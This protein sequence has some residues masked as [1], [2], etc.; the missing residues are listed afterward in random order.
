[1]KVLATLKI[2]KSVSRPQY[3]RKNAVKNGKRLSY[4]VSLLFECIIFFHRSVEYN[5]KLTF[6]CLSYILTYTLNTEITN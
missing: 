2:Y 1:M 5:L 3:I 4:K 6:V